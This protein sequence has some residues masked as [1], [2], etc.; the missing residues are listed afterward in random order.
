MWRRGRGPHKRSPDARRQPASGGGPGGEGALLPARASGA[1]RLQGGAA[2]RAHAERL[3]RGLLT[4]VIV[5]ARS[6]HE[7]DIAAG[8]DRG[9]QGGA[10]P[11][12]NQGRVSR[13]QQPR[14]S[15]HAACATAAPG[16][17][18]CHDA[19]PLEDQQ[20]SSQ[21]ALKTQPAGERKT[22]EQQTNSEHRRP[23]LLKE[24]LWRVAAPLGHAASHDA[25]AQRVERVL[26]RLHALVVVHALQAGRQAGSQRCLESA[27]VLLVKLKLMWLHALAACP[28]KTGSRCAHHGRRKSLQMQ[29]WQK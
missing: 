19:A 10:S 29:A 8:A 16:W 17:A 5:G 18:A 28:R 24:A 13:R 14:P 15:R 26:A 6:G 25:R 7:L 20:G 23:S 22:N 2:D 11:G 4:G 21:I 1:K 12:G 9:R 27:E 3:A